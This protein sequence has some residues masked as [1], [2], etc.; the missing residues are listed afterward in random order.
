MST[1]NNIFINT[2]LRNTENYIMYPSKTSHLAFSDSL[3]E[4]Y[5]G[6]ANTQYDCVHSYLQART[7]V[8]TCLTTNTYLQIKRLKVK[9]VYSHRYSLT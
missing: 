9:K 5:T 2:G 8:C 7:V 3:L 4:M 6:V 1:G